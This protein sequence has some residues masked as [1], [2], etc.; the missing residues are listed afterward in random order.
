MTSHIG[1]SFGSTQKL[2][3]VLGWC[4][5][6]WC[7]LSSQYI[8]PS[9]FMWYVKNSLASL[10]PSLGTTLTLC[11]FISKNDRQL[12]IRHQNRQRR[13]VPLSNKNNISYPRSNRTP[14]HLNFWINIC[15]SNKCDTLLV[16]VC[17]LCL[18]AYRCVFRNL[19]TLE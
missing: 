19:L 3:P 17:R 9:R 12:N 15:H 11:V 7:N 1:S 6:H 2:M 16:L 5:C 14:T 8:Y 4:R 10:L 18:V 13:I